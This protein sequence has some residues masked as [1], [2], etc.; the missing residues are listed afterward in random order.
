MMNLMNDLY[1]RGI[2]ALVRVNPNL[3][4]ASLMGAVADLI[5]E[6]A[7]WVGIVLVITAAMNFFLALKDENAEAQ[8]RAIKLLVIGS[9]LVGFGTLL[10]TVGIIS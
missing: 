4:M 7:K 1:A 10:R 6:I 2:L 3:D 5:I 9:C 8:S